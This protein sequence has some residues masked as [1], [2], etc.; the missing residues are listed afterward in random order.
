MQILACPLLLALFAFLSSVPNT[1]GA[2][3]QIRRAHWPSAKV[4][5]VSRAQKKDR[6]VRQS[7]QTVNVR[8]RVAA[9]QPG[10][11][12]VKATVDRNRVRLGELVT[13]TL[14]PA[15]V[16][17]DPRYIVTIFFGDR[18]QQP[19]LQAR[20]SHLYTESGTFTY[21]ILVKASKA[22][23]QIP[24]VKLSATPT[25]VKPDSLV[26]FKAELS[27]DYPNIK[28]RFV[29]ADGSQTDWQDN[30]VA[31]HIYRSPGTYPAYVDIG[32]GNGRSAKQVGGS[33]RRVIEVTSPRLATIAVQLTAD[34]LT[35]AAKDAV[36]FLARVDPTVPDIKYRFN[37][38]DRSRSTVWQTSS[39][40]AHVYSS[41]GTYRA[42]VEVRVTNSRSGQQS[43]SS[44]PLSIKVEPEQPPI[45]VDLF[46]APQSVAAGL[47]VFV[48][49][50]A[51][52]ANSQT[53][54]RFN[55]GDGSPPSAWQEA[56]EET[57]IYSLAGTYA[58]FVEIGRPG[59]ETNVIASSARKQV[60]VTTGIIGTLGGST[61]TPQPSASPSPNG[62]ASPSNSPGPSPSPN[63]SATPFGSLNESPTVTVT[64]TP[65][66]GSTPLGGEMNSPS[67]GGSPSPSATE[68][69][70]PPADSGL[71]DNWWKYV[72]VAALI[73]FG[74]YQGWKY[75]F[76]PGATLEPH[77]DP[78]VAALGTE[79]GPLAIN[80]QMELDPDVTDGQFTVDTTEG[81]L[82]KS[83]R[84]SDG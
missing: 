26:N 18:K 41:A 31:T 74:G 13:F 14:S 27:H 36:T 2:T 19:V 37:F 3:M 55:F 75:F 39:R 34:R 28:Y 33:L 58:A 71:R 11:P 65:Q 63:G 81:S 66:I 73:L 6:F 22:P 44:T 52:S 23:A 50:T 69:P 30:Q 64:S 84:K 9:S 20:F 12:A 59:D 78:G 38:G 45:G 46:V 83:E 47:P 8:P 76:V 24:E 43:A 17:L 57:H 42:A 51:K 16:V 48:R 32:L 68:S 53:R 10:V 82:I 61:P 15:S 25:S 72:L 35:V 56:R 77:V 49:A 21:S 7:P 80:F 62:S 60:R 70:S 1:P 29:F 5:Q 79:G 67:P 54:Y 4:T 40:I